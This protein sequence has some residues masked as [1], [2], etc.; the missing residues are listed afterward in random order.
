MFFHI[1]YYYSAVIWTAKGPKSET[2]RVMG[3]S[4]PPLNFT[5]FM[6]ANTPSTDRTQTPQSATLTVDRD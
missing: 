4:P 1:L 2:S 5:P 3:G 6:S